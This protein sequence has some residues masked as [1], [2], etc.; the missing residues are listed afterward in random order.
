V[1]V[2]LWVFDGYYRSYTVA[3]CG[4]LLFG[5]TAGIHRGLNWVGWPARPVVGRVATVVLA[6][7]SG[8]PPVLGGIPFAGAVVLG[9]GLWEYI[10][11]QL[12]GPRTEVSAADLEAGLRPD[13]RWLVI[14]G[15]ALVDKPVVWKQRGFDEERAMCLVSQQWQPNEPVSVVVSAR[16]DRPL[17]H[18]ADPT[19]VE[20]TATVMGVPGLV[21]TSFEQYGVRVAD[22]AFYVEVGSTPE[23]ANHWGVMAAVG[24]GAVLLCVAFG[25]VRAAWNSRANTT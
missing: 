15:R 6:G 13:S 22:G 9:I 8:L 19:K 11:A 5:V 16:S 12:A 25:L 21:R 10:P 23:T 17:P 20:G 2:Q 4:L 7:W 18:G 3:A 14:E 1:D 24:A